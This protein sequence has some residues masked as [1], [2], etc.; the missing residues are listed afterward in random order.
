MSSLRF[1]A[2]LFGHF[3]QVMSQSSD[4]KT[5]GFRDPWENIKYT[6]SKESLTPCCIDCNSKDY[7]VYDPAK[8]VPM[9]G[10]YFA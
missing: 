4:W 9:N 7:L 10:Q 8:S 3:C 6:A 1:F 5:Q 2:T